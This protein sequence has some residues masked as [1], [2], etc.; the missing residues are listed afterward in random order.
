MLFKNL[1][2]HRLPAEWTLTAADLEGQL[3][4]RTL[5]PCGPFEMSSRGWVPVTNGGRLLHTVNQQHMIA[6]GENQKLLPGSIIRQIAQERAD[7]QAEEQGFPVGRKQM[8]DLRARVADELRARALTRRRVTRAWIDPSA[9]WFAVDA[10]GGA[11]AEAVIETLGDT[12]GS[13][14]P[15]GIDIE[16]SPQAAMTSWLLRGEAPGRFSIDDDLELHAADK[17]KTII[18]Y[19]RHPLDGK[20]IQAHLS[21]GKY[22]TRLGLTWHDRVSFVLTEKLQIKRL[23]FLE[24]SKDPADG[25]DGVDPAEQFD[26]DFAVMAGELSSL[27]KDLWH[28]LGKEAAEAAEWPARSKVA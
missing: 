5:Q 13:F 23:D 2:F 27:L 11:R 9:G 8:R 22:P 16:R 17:T 21:T 24:M 15:V 28:A 6:L 4:G 18:R 14:A 10:A 26:I 12:L 1:V 20:E 7:I 25:D 19:T 3:A